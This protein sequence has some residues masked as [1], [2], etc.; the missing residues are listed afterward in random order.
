MSTVYF[1]RI[2][3]IRI[4]ATDSFECNTFFFKMNDL[5]MYFVAHT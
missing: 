1:H 3:Y 5:I 4:Y 2:I